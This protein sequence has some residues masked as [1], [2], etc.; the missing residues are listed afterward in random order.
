MLTTKDISKLKG[1]T[2]LCGALWLGAGACAAGDGA[3]GVDQVSAPIYAATD[4]LWLSPRASLNTP[5]TVCFENPDGWSQEIGWVHDAVYST[6]QSA[7]GITFSGFGRCG[8]ANIRVQID[9]SQPRVTGG[10]GAAMDTMFLNFTYKNWNSANCAGNREFCIRANA[11]HE[12]GHALGLAHEANRPDSQCNQTEGD[13]GDTFFAYDADSV[14][15]Y[16]APYRTDLSPGDKDGIRR[17]YGTT[18][19]DSGHAYGLQ[20]QLGG[21]LIG[22][23]GTRVSAAGVSMVRTLSNTNVVGISRSD[24]SGGTL[25]RYDTGV[26]VTAGGGYVAIGNSGGTRSTG[27]LGTTGLPLLVSATPF[28]WT[29]ERGSAG[30]GGP[31]ITVRKPF[32]L[33]G[34]FAGTKYYLATSVDTSRTATGVQTV[35]LTTDPNQARAEWRLLG[36]IEKN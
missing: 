27:G 19:I 26:Y 2:A 35:F 15:N 14:M 36:P 24:T 4:D 23:A 29:V 20:N 30:V 6:W 7:T 9:D 3:A 22:S 17:L 31:V 13:Y 28:V 12:F 32:V 18:N 33:S 5:L 21:Y 16:C 34:V 8:S 10:L 25:V 11:I 1:I